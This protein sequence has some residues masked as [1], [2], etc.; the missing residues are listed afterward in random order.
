MWGQ[1]WNFEI[2]VGHSPLLPKIMYASYNESQIIRTCYEG[3]NTKM[4]RNKG[5]IGDRVKWVFAVVVLIWNE[6]APCVFS[7]IIIL[8][9][10]QS[11]V[12]CYL[13][14][15]IIKVKVMTYAQ[16][17]SHIICWNITSNFQHQMDT[18]GHVCLLPHTSS[19]GCDFY[20]ILGNHIIIA[21]HTRYK[22]TRKTRG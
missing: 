6:R 9:Q 1:F 11:P 21:T 18:E 17:I 14:V 4:S 20:Q 10:S 7:P 15:I 2:F 16:N 13:S 5:R 3:K 22:I 19:S 12:F 8:I